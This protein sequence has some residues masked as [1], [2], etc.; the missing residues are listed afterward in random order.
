[1]ID[2]FFH[3]KMKLTFFLFVCSASYVKG[4]SFSNVPSASKVKEVELK[5]IKG[6]ISSSTTSRSK[7]MTSFITNVSAIT[8][9]SVKA[10]NASKDQSANIQLP[11]YIDFL[12]EKNTSID[13]SKIL[14]KGAD[15][16]IQL[17][18]IADAAARLNQIPEIAA[19]K[20]WSQIQGILTGPLGTLL[21]TMTTLSK[22]SDQA[23]KAAGKVK[24]DLILIGKE[25]SNKNVENIVKA[26]EAALSD[27]ESFAKIV[28]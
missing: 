16:E 5:G 4:L 11:S 15:T 22:D 14:Y 18:R 2:S 7:F 12:I 20:K 9:L 19:Q 1:M 28:F 10:A 25:S 13:T 8:F 27:L 6:S 24:A 26:T 23:K 17:K 3:K 21:Q